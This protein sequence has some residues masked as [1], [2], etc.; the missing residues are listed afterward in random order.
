MERYSD[1]ELIYLMRCGYEEA[2][3]CLYEE[4]YQEVR[5]WLLQFHYYYTQGIDYEDCVQIAM[6][7]FSVIINS[8]RD[9]QETS[10]K[11]FMKKAVVRRILTFLSSS[12]NYMHIYRYGISLNQEI[13]HD[14]DLKYEDMIADKKEEYQP[15]TITMIKE[16]KHYY[17]TQLDLVVTPMEKKV[18][19][20]K[21]QGYSNEEIADELNMS[22]KSV[23][24]A[25]YRY[26]KKAEVIDDFK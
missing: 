12:K 24:N 8:Y 6:M 19:S 22:L 26:H 25:T 20:L 3:H 17:Q 14:E 1:D 21:E 5:K 2:E 11:T 13:I 15:D 10:L 7:N 16:K 18:I 9:D 23:Y 4:Y